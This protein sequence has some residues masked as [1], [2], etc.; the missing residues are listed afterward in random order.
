MVRKLIKRIYNRMVISTTSKNKF[1]EKYL[2]WQLINII[3]KNMWGNPSWKNIPKNI[4]NLRVILLV[5]ISILTL[6]IVSYDIGVHYNDSKINQL[7]STIDLKDNHLSEMSVTESKLIKYLSKKDHKID[8]LKKFLESREYIEFVIQKEAKI[9]D[10]ELNMSRVSDSILFLMKD[11]ADKYEI[12]YTIYFRLIDKE[13]G[14]KF[15]PNHGGSG[16][17]GYMQLMPY[18]F[19]A[20]SKKLGLS[21]GHTKRNNVLVGSYMLYKNHKDWMERGKTDY[22]AW[23]FALAEYN[24][25]ESKMIIR[26]DNGD[27]IGYYIP[28]YTKSYINYIM[29]YYPKINS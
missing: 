27:K 8:S 1:Y 3:E 23:K 6:S 19:K 13:S 16:A 7:E 14:Y 25:G 24:A 28:N 17:F 11:Q 9:D 29:K 15:I 20:Y 2:R 18:T 4:W 10:F 5:S 26:N 12:P 21:G 22:N